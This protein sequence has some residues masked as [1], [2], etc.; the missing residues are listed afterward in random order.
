MNAP[1]R[2]PTRLGTVSRRLGK[3]N[4]FRNSAAPKLN[5]KWALIC[6]FIVQGMQ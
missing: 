6:I 3:K 2:L 5:R 1:L 4:L